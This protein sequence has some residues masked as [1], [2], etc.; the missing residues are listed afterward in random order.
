MKIVAIFAVV[1]LSL[2]SVQFDGEPFDAF[3]D[4]FENW[5]DVE[6]LED[7]FEENRN[8]LQSGFFGN[9][10]VEN[11]VL[12]TIEEAEKFEQRLRFFAN[13]G[14]VNQNGQTL[15]EIFKLLSSSDIT[16]ELVKSKA[17]GVN[18]PSWLRIYALRIAENVYVVTGGAIK[19]TPTMNE[20]THLKR[21]LKKLEIAKQYLLENGLLD[22]ND[23]DFV[24]LNP[25]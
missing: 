2:L 12:A 19:L 15:D 14:V 10:T 22:L 9:A 21:E 8:D 6:Y 1:N 7:F 24:E 23:F 11:A 3:T 25:L 17:Y 13:N 18:N 4:V 5:N 20:R 16:Y